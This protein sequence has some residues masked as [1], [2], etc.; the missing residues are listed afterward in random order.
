MTQARTARTPVS[1]VAAFV[2]ILVVLHALPLLAQAPSFRPAVNYG[3]RGYVPTSV[4]LGDLNGDGILD[5][6]VANECVI[7]DT[8][9]GP[10]NGGYVCFSEEYCAHGALG[11]LLGNGDGTFRP[12]VTYET[13]GYLSTSVAMG[14]LNGDG[15]LDLVVTNQCGAFPID[16]DGNCP[17][18][19]VDVMYGNGD[20]TLGP[21]FGRGVSGWMPIS[22]ALG[23]L[24]GD[25]KPEIVVADLCSMPNKC[26]DEGCTCTAGSV[27]VPGGTYDS[28]AR[29]ARSMALGDVNRDGNL[30]V[31]V[32]NDGGVGL[33]LGNGNG[34][35]QPAVLF[36]AGPY[37]AVADV[38]S[39]GK[40]DL[41]SSWSNYPSYSGMVNVLLGNGDGTFKPGV[42]YPSGGTFPRSL[43]V[44]DVNGDGWPDLIVG[45]SALGVLIG[46]G[47]GTFQPPITF[48]SGGG[49][50]IAA[51]DLNKDGKPDLVVVNG[52]V[53]VLLN[54]S[55]TQKRTTATT[56][57]SSLN[58]SIYG[59]KITFMA[60]VTTSGPVPATGT[61]VFMWRYFTQTHTIGTATMNSSGVATLT[62]SN[63][64]AG[65]YPMT[66]VYRGDTNNLSSTSTVLNQTVLQTTSKATLA[67]SP[68]PSTVGQAVTFTAKITSPTVTPTGPVTFTLAKTAL[69]TAQLSGGKAT[70]TTSS[71]PAGSN[72]IKVTY[73]GNSNIARSSAEVTQVV[74]P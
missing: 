45:Q 23:D 9:P 39:D 22:V 10:D 53:G 57:A 60:Q 61:V 42:T 47:D 65:L 29:F 7:G 18:A 41:M 43:A 20:G 63:L 46:N 59:Q 25:G 30:D 16:S 67:S 66:A 44:A 13:S 6:V 56:L 40:L 74:Q 49:S 24:N 58:P 19:T 32:G 51:G 36:S 17:Y 62:K 73:Y 68:N 5:I 50:P 69:G 28:G 70:F 31:L 26:S 4:A 37:I 21:P 3:T 8:C 1:W 15:K 33:L 12:A 34:T 54:N 27:E 72:G 64:N 14:D 2:A 71:L 38:S 55:Q 11:V 35:L 48:D 52:N